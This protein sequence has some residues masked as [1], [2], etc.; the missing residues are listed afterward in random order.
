MNRELKTVRL[1]RKECWGEWALLPLRLMIGFG[2]VAHGYAKLSA[3]PEKFVD[4][5][6]AIGVPA[7]GLAGWVTPFVE[8]CGGLAV[9][10]GALL[11]LVSIPLAL[12]LL[13]AM[14]TVHL[15][16]GFSSIKLMAITEH[17]PL[18]GTPGYEVDLLYLAGLLTLVL[19]GP[20]P[21]SVDRLLARRKALPNAEHL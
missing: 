14:F 11:P 3:G 9:I 6:Q 16:F 19:G 2:F 13:V 4:I 10:A 7:P 20:G 5:L 12:I 17:G 15:P 18:F 1:G 8:L 21:F